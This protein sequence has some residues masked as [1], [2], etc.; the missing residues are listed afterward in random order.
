M[1]PDPYEMMLRDF[2]REFA[3]PMRYKLLYVD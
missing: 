3:S 1:P 2:S